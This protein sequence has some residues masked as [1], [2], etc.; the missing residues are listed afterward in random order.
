MGLIHW[1]GRQTAGSGN[2]PNTRAQSA[3]NGVTAKIKTHANRYRA[4]R[5]ALVA[6][7]PNAFK[8]ASRMDPS[9]GNWVKV[10]RELSDQ[11]IRNPR[12]DDLD[13]APPQTSAERRRQQLGEGHKE[14]PWIWTSVRP[15][16][17]DHI[18]SDRVSDE[19]AV[20]GTHSS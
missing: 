17:A 6:L 19:E 14:I 18:D 16:G 8:L 10:F 5:I 13:E 11:D 2:K 4:A 9:E 12:G 20:E 7:N 3:I 1:K 15:T